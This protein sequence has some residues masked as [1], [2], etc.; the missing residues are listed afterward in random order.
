MCPQTE[1]EALEMCQYPYISIV[2]SLMYL[3]LTTRPDI[4]YAARVLARFNSNPGLPHWQAAKHVLPSFLDLYHHYPFR[5]ISP[6]TMP[7][8]ASAPIVDHPLV[9]DVLNLFRAC[10]FL[11]CKHLMSLV[12]A[13]VKGGNNNNIMWIDLLLSAH[14]HLL[15]QAKALAPP[16]YPL[17]LLKRVMFTFLL[18]VINS[19][20][21]ALDKFVKTLAPCWCHA[22]APAPSSPPAPSLE[23]VNVQQAQ[24]SS[25]D[26]PVT[27]IAVD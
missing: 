12:L 27:S 10:W 6:P 1:A 24:H 21:S 4:A 2:G 26:M 16:S 5:V 15:C 9:F 22:P 13:A 20:G 3:A 8:T 14:T 18:E 7:S 25:T 23:L 17:S 19:C 11:N